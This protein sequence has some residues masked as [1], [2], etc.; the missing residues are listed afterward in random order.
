ME[1][2]YIIQQ[3]SKR[4]F[5]NPFTEISAIFVSLKN[6]QMTLATKVIEGYAV[7]RLLSMLQSIYL[8]VSTV[9]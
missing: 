3:V 1:I 9:F 2:Y 5:Q 7:L 8:P 6:A 4:T